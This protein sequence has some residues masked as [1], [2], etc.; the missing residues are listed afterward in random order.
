MRSRHLFLILT[1][2]AGCGTTTV[3]PVS[4][5]GCYNLVWATP[6]LATAHVLRLE[7]GRPLHI[8]VRDVNDTGRAAFFISEGGDTLAEGWWVAG[9]QS[10]FL[11]MSPP[12]EGVTVTVKVLGTRIDAQ[13]NAV[14][15]VGQ[16]AFKG[17][18]ASCPGPG[19]T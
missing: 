12:F 4:I 14:P 11:S 19:A 8:S 9:N 13:Y 16:A 6:E 5:S 2:I 7:L 15:H 3:S 17:N 1:L 10:L 18:R